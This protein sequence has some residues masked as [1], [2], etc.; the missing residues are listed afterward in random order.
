MEYEEH[1]G[2]GKPMVRLKMSVEK[3]ES[4]MSKERHSHLFLASPYAEVR[5]AGS[6]GIAQFL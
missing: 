2:M 3:T 6:Y 1:R 5:H 4:G